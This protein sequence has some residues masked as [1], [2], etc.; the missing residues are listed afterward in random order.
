MSSIQSTVFM[1]LQTNDD[2]RPIIEALQRDNPD[3]VVHRLP[4][5]V[6]IDAPR[7]LV[8]RRSTVE[9][10]LG[11]DWDL[12]SINLNLISLSGNVD[13]SEDEMIL[14]WNR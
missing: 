3:A 6:K 1:A 10:I 11:T 2:T 12:Q 5:M 8:L 4:A 13:E 7:R 14:H 9:E